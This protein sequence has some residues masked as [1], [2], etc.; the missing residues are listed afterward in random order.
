MEMPRRPPAL[1]RSDFEKVLC[2]DHEHEDAEPI[3]D[4]IAEERANVCGWV[5]LGVHENDDRE[6]SRDQDAKRMLAKC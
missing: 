4:G 6:D 2:G 1:A 5:G 3:G